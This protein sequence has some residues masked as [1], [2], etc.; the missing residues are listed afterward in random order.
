MADIQKMKKRMDNKRDEKP[1]RSKGKGT[2]STGAKPAHSGKNTAGT[3]RS[4]EKVR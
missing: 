4:R 1:G 3:N 2:G